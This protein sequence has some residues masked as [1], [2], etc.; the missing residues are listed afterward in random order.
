[1][2]YSEFKNLVLGK[3]FDIDGAFGNQC[4]DGYAKYCIENGVPYANCT[5]SGY[6]KDIWNLRHSNGILNYFDEVEVMQAGDVVVFAESVYTPYS[7]IA[8]FDSDV[9]GVFG[10]FLGQNQGGI[11]GAFNLCE[12]PY[13][14]TYPTAFRLKEQKQTSVLD[15]LQAEDGIATL[16]VDGVLARLNGPKGEVVRIYS[17]NDEVR[18][19]HKYVGN[20]H[21]YVVWKEGQSYIFLAVSNSEIRGKEPWATFRAPSETKEAS[22]S[23]NDKKVVSE[24]LAKVGEFPKSVKYKGV[25]I[26][27]LN[28]D[29][30]LNHYD[31]VIIR[32]AYGTNTDSKF[33]EN[34]KKCQE[35]NKPFGVYLYDY[36]LNDEQA[37]EQAQYM[38]DLLQDNN[39]VPQCGVWFDMEDADGYKI[40]NNVLNK[41]RVNHS[42]KAFCDLLKAH[43]YYVGVYASS[44]W[45][46]RYIET[47]YPKWVA[48]WGTN[49]GSC[50]A[51]F[52]D[53]AIMHQFS[54][55]DIDRDV[56]YVDF[57]KL[58]SIPIVQA[59]TQSVQGSTDEKLDYGLINKLIQFIFDL[60]KSFKLK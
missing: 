37:N 41:E 27:D 29:V 35:L 39:I 53:I 38:L 52:S 7:H 20:G 1:M 46:D 56:L 17:T 40:K 42:I 30:N 21:R 5:Q 14:A 59:S 49:D 8:I 4:W 43:G 12:V 34:V 60:L 24:K 58:K 15:S 11:N 6:V 33:F 26:S 18:Y 48:N 22:I 54:S 31:F 57:E 10:R 9:N 19:T 3:G 32:G 16:T 51:D 36:A 2:E 23:Q 50:Q 47:D 55:V 25:D 28:G 44:S 45:F 13:S